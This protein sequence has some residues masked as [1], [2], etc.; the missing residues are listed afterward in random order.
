MCVLDDGPESGQRALLGGQ[1]VQLHEGLL[2]PTTRKHCNEAAFISCALQRFGPD[3]GSR[4]RSHVLVP[5]LGLWSS[6]ES[7]GHVGRRFVRLV[8]GRGACFT[9]HFQLR[10]RTDG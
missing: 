5:G 4:S 10:V 7:R 6:S 2:D 1:I 3:V 8:V 9:H